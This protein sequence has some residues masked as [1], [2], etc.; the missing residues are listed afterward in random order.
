MEREDEA[1]AMSRVVVVVRWA[2]LKFLFRCSVTD[3]FDMTV[4]LT[5]LGVGLYLPV[6]RLARVCHP[7]PPETTFTIT[8]GG[9]ALRRSRQTLN[10]PL[11]GVRRLR[12]GSNCA[13]APS[14]PRRACVDASVV[15]RR[16]PVR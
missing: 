2:P 16:D 14:F 6:M 8:H 15:L 3:V 13:I 4:G 9:F 10:W 12:G 1:I 11:T 5:T 7:C